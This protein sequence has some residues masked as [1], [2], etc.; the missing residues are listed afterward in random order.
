[1]TVTAIN[2][3]PKGAV[4]NS[5]E[6]ISI[7]KSM[8]PQDTVW[9]TVSS[10]KE[11]RGEAR[12]SPVD[13]ALTATDVLFIAFPL[14]VDGLPAS[15]MEYLERYAS[16]CS[17][18]PRTGKKQRVFAVAN[19]GFY[20]GEQNRTV[21]EIV[22][23]FCASAGLD[24]CGGAGIGTGEMILGI[25][26]VSPEAGI[27]KPVFRAI[28]L[29]ASAMAAADGRLAEPVFAQHGFPWLMY[30]LAGE[31]GW[32]SRI[33]KSGLARKDIDARPLALPAKAA[34]S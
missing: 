7:L 25:K 21:L 22:E 24:W 10:I 14:Y 27:R 16:A 1:M 33:R 15:L 6:V 12:N 13:P 26:N 32:R 19:C 8:L 5:L 31:A 3:S 34:L 9:H 11:S 29:V 2:G 20:E 30:K 23:H 17:A 18:L 28:A 4:S